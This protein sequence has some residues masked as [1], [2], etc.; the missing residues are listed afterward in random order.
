MIPDHARCKTMEPQGERGRMM[1]C[2]RTLGLVSALALAAMLSA[3]TENSSKFETT[4]RERVEKKNTAEEEQQGR[5]TARVKV[6]TCQFPVSGDIRRNAAYI[7][8]YI[9]EAASNGAHLVHF[10]EAA[11]SGYAG[12]DVPSFENYNWEQLRTE[13]AN[14]VSLAKQCGVWVVLGS[15][16]YI[17][18]N[19]KP[20]NCLY[21]ISAEG[22]IVERYDKSRLTKVDT[23]FYSR[24]EHLALFTVQGVCFGLLICADSGSSDLYAAYKKQG[25]QVVLHSFY[26]AR[27]R[28]GTPLDE[29]I[30]AQVRI[31]ALES[32]LWVVANNSSAPYS[33]WPT[34]I[35]RPDGTIAGSLE[36]HKPGLL[37]H[38]FPDRTHFSWVECKITTSPRQEEAYDPGSPSTHPR[39]V[40]RTSPP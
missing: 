35:A 15:T 6:A 20:T 38:E 31:R 8:G 21:V 30:P 40:D 11:L 23:K 22:K 13:T 32:D 36:R 3:R 5:P 1:C 25:V 28:K 34:F 18:P 19:D 39:A 17:G 12:S 27:F 10:S 2:H 14:I 26:N 24:G 4:T 9:R 33:C 29:V 16:H 7:K 37:Y